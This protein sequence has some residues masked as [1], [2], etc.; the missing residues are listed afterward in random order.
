MDTNHVRA[1]R[2]GQ[3]ARQA[4]II[5][6]LNTIYR[7][8]S[9]TYHIQ[10]KQRTEPRIYLLDFTLDD[11]NT[12]YST[13]RQI[14]ERGRLRSKGNETFFVTK[15]MEH[16]ILCDNAIY[17][18]RSS[19]SDNIRTDANISNTNTAVLYEYIPIDGRNTIIEINGQNTVLLDESYYIIDSSA[20]S[21]KHD[22]TYLRT[23]LSS[24][25][26][27]VRRVKKIVK[28]HPKSMNAFVFILNEDETSVIDFYITTE[29][30][31]STHT[32]HTP[33]RE[34]T[35]VNDRLTRTCKEDIISFIE[36]FKLC[37]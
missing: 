26:V 12:Q 28:T 19:R 20:S 5:S 11:M 27:V 36:H 21:S 23:I 3:T 37:S 32:P 34:D 8:T 9:S 14:I 35:C 18:I 31:V 4:M 24:H 6:G 25:H 15:H 29:N 1:Q 2:H 10:S 17:E 30:G 33:I 16:F 13:I 7:N 22:D